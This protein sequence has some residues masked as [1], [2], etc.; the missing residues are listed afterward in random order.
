MFLN[1]MQKAV[2]MDIFLGSGG[3]AFT[4]LSEES[5][6]PQDEDPLT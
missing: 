4:R 1:G 3:V 2:Y 5:I 6:T